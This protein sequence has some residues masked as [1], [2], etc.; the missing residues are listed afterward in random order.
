MNG[1]YDIVLIL[2]IFGAVGQCFNEFHVFGVVIPDAGTTVTEDMAREYQGA[3]T[4]QSADDF[5]WTNV[6]ISGLKI[7][8]SA[9]LAVFTVI[10]LIIS[11]CQAVGVDLVTAATLALVVQVPIWFVTIAGWYE[12]S[13]GRSL[14]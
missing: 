3:S 9:V 12:W 7:I 2:M 13:T 14:T 4:P 10:P 6:I 8:G 5:T 11:L 1:L